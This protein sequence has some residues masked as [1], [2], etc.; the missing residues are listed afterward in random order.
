MVLKLLW[1]LHLQHYPL[2]AM[3]ISSR[4]IKP[5][6]MAKASAAKA[7]A[8]KP[9]IRP[10]APQVAIAR[11]G[12]PAEP[13]GPPAKASAS[14][15]KP[16]EGVAQRISKGLKDPCSPPK[17]AESDTIVFG[18]YSMD[19]V[20]PDDQLWVVD[21]FGAY[22]CHGF[23]AKHPLWKSQEGGTGLHDDFLATRK[24]A[25]LWYSAHFD[26]YFLSSEVVKNSHDDSAWQNATVIGW[27]SKDLQT[28]Y[29][30]WN[31]ETACTNMK[32]MSI[33]EYCMQQRARVTGSTPAT[34]PGDD[35]SM[36]PPAPPAPAPAIPLAP[37]QPDFLEGTR[38]LRPPPVPEGTKG[39][40]GKAY[41][42]WKPEKP[43]LK[44]GAK[45]RLCAMLVAYRTGNYQ[46]ATYLTNKYLVVHKELNFGFCHNQY[47]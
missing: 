28:M 10:A 47:E 9:V 1:H 6:P 2:P 44:T 30:P 15:S 23:Y 43:V 33:W 7:A 20:I 31:S 21:Y 38:V 24:T 41:G 42:P 32:I 8:P 17:V 18:K 39:G 34:S 19:S 3:V 40:G 36:T 5:G 37:S 25:Y 29:S 16:A 4:F 14:G 22:H 26:T 11:A 46:R 45:A 13:P 12:K 27:V 35:V